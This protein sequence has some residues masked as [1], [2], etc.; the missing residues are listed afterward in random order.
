MICH[1]QHN[2]YFHQELYHLLQAKGGGTKAEPKP[3]IDNPNASA[4][5]QSSLIKPL[6]LK[7][8]ASG[9]SPGK[10]HRSI[11]KCSIILPGLNGH[12]PR[13]VDCSKHFCS[14]HQFTL[15]LL[16]SLA[17]LMQIVY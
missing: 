9:G 12:I 3:M 15:E 17:L 11:L 14:L 7:A 10:K 5:K 13:H 2:K 16:I 4:T 6:A 1:N 8:S